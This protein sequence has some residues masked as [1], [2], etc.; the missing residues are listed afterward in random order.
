LKFLRILDARIA[1][2]SPLQ[3]MKLEHLCI[4]DTQVRDLSPLRGMPLRYLEM[5]RLGSV[6]DFS[7]L[8]DMQ[9]TYLNIAGC[10][11]TDLSLLRS[12]PLKGVW[13]DFK[14]E[15]DTELLRSIKTLEKINGKPAA[16]FWKQVNGK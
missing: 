13:C 1:D 11:L 7:V 8:Q 6:T 2:L 12:K 9:L 3:G 4:G 16:E 14:P 5:W 15:R 10:N